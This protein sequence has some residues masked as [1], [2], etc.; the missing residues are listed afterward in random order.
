MGLGNTTD[1]G[2]AEKEQ[3]RDKLN[4]YLKYATYDNENHADDGN[5]RIS[6]EPEDNHTIYRAVHS[7]DGSLKRLACEVVY[8]TNRRYFLKYAE[9]YLPNAEDREEAVQEL[10]GVELYRDIEKFNPARASITVF[11]ELRAMTVFQRKYG[12]TV[13]LKTK[14]YID[15][16]IRVKTAKNEIYEQT[17]DENPSE[18]D[19]L[20][21]DKRSGRYEKSL[22]LNAIRVAEESSK[23]V[24]S[25][26]TMEEVGLELAAPSRYEP[27]NVYAAQESDKRLKTALGKIEQRYRRI[28]IKALELNT[29]APAE[30]NRQMIKYVRTTIL[31][32]SKATD[33]RARAYIE[34]AYNEFG[35]ALSATSGSRP[36][37]QENR[38]KL[39]FTRSLSRDLYEREVQDI[40]AALEED[41]T[42]FD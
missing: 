15:A 6:I 1:L 40:M 33:E 16:A 17:R 5:I 26:T 24:V 36:R 27:H 18:Y 28:I 19:I 10:L 29:L 23:R 4:R 12:E 25:T 2:E 31:K 7:G 37:E 3:I 38:R 21:Q 34:A 22:S 20:E 39:S 30:A 8:R 14:H 11:L 42:F 32:D 9:K 13:G 35:R 41:T